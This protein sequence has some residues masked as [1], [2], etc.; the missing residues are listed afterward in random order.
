MLLRWP[1]VLGSAS[2]RRV[3]LLAQL[4][5]RPTVLPLDVDEDAS[6]T[7]EEQLREVVRRKRIALRAAVSAEPSALLLVADTMVVQDGRVLGKPRGP[8]EH[9]D[10]LR[11]LSGRRH[12]VW[13]RFALS[14]SQAAADH[15]EDAQ[16][17][18]TA[19]ELR[20]LS[21]AE[22][23]AYVGMGEGKDKAGGYAIQGKAAAF[24]R[25]IEGSYGAVVGLP[26]CEVVERLH[27]LD[28]VVQGF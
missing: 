7:P 22:I 25:K 20:E 12:E 8:A 10:T 6:G 21:A 9:A 1:L 13:T 15:A 5:L 19:V 3:E 28:A 4:G 17:V 11:Q 23:D 18:R 14:L 24:I 16:T 27:R 2:P 26:L